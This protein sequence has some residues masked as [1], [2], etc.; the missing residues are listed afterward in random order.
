MR[1]WLVERAY[2]DKGLVRLTYATEDGTRA[3]VRERS[4]AMLGRVEVT[5]AAEIDPDRLEPV[6]D[7]ATR[8]RYAAEAER[9]RNRHDPDDGV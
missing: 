2:D 7:P 6:E 8:E 1:C 4:A 9:M 5:A 3:I